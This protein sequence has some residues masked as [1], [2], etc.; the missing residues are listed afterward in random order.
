[1]SSGSSTASTKYK[2]STSSS[3]SAINAAAIRKQLESQ[4]KEYIQNR[5]K[6]NLG[7][8]TVSQTSH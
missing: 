8:K 3:L 6:S 7:S 2:H 4:A 5:N 1:M